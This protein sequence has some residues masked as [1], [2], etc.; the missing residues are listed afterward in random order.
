VVAE[1]T[2]GHELLEWKRGFFEVGSL[3]RAAA[4]FIL[5]VAG[6]RDLELETL[7]AWQVRG[8]SGCALGSMCPGYHQERGP[9]KGPCGAR[10]LALGG[11]HSNGAG[12]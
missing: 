2:R 1:A 12:F 3:R 5:A 9:F 7:R 10:G 8:A 11:C 6:P 4:A